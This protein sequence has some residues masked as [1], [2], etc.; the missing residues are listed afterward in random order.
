MHARIKQRSVYPTLLGPKTCLAHPE[1]WLMT[2]PISLLDL[3]WAVC[4]NPELEPICCPGSWFALDGEQVKYLFNWVHCMLSSFST[5][6]AC[7][8]GGYQSSLHSFRLSQCFGGDCRSIGTCQVTPSFKH[9]LKW[10]W[11]KKA[12]N[13][14]T[15]YEQFQ[16]K[17]RLSNW[18]L[19]LWQNGTVYLTR[20]FSHSLCSGLDWREIITTLEV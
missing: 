11:K 15:S 2:V 6:R 7:G 12:I 18:R 17:T 4:S 10:M 14:F 13:Y 3:P 8:E 19:L 20:I 1:P 9:M 5:G 16:Q